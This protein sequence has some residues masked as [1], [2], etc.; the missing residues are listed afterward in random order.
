MTAIGE[1]IETTALPNTTNGCFEK[2]LTPGGKLAQGSGGE[3]RSVVF[4]VDSHNGSER[5]AQTQ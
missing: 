2:A 3:G 5:G 1:F 4:G